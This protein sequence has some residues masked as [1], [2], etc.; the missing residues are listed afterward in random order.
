MLNVAQSGFNRI[1]KITALKH[2]VFASPT[3]L[4]HFPQNISNT[5]NKK[6]KSRP[7]HFQQIPLPAITDLLPF[8]PYS[9][10]DLL[11]PLLPVWLS[12]LITLDTLEVSVFKKDEKE[13]QGGTVKRNGLYILGN[14]L[15]VNFQKLP[16][17]AEWLRP[18]VTLV[19]SVR[20]SHC[21]FQGMTSSR[22]ESALITR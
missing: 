20:G 19:L 17:E 13:K 8:S 6:K 16:L 9:H 21:V 3:F 4:L 12:A 2:W 14:I 5:N 18:Q 1:R 15:R 11:K 22:V 10:P 7:S